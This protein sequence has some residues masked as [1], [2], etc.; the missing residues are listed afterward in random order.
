[1]AKFLRWLRFVVRWALRVPVASHYW[2]A[3]AVVAVSVVAIGLGG[4]TE[5]AF[6]LAGMVLQLGG[7]CTVVLGILKTRADFGQPTVRSQFK[8]W[9]KTFPPLNPPPV[10]ISINATLPGL[11]GEMYMSSTHGPS[12]DQ[13]V[14]GRIGHLEMIV[15]KLDEALGKTHIAVLQAEKKAQQALDAQA[16]QFTGQIDGVT[17]KIE[18]SA[19]GGIHL[20]AVGVVLLFV[21]T[22]FGGAAPEL[23]HWFAVAPALSGQ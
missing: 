2:W 6:R 1:M 20:S 15:R 22:I 12:A 10:T 18:A 5:T 7:V 9:L 3:I 16:L 13:S 17:K 14:E 19:T 11:F 4:W 23:G 21:G 8:S